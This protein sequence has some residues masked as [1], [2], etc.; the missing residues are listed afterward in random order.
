MAPPR[1]PAA[2][3]APDAPGVT[4]LLLAW[5]AGDAAALDALIPVVYAEL[6]TQARRAMRRET[7]GHTLQ[8][9][10]LVHEAFL[11]L[12][13]QRRIAWRNRAQFFGVAAQLMR[14]IL[15]DSL[16]ARRATKR[17][18]GAHRLTL[19]DA[20]V[21][22]EA[23]GDEVLALHEALE[24]LAALDPAQARLVELRYFGGL[25]IEEAAEVLGV[26]AAT[27]KREWAVAR[28]WLR[29]ELEDA[30]E[31]PAPDR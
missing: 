18:G 24:R 25:T 1:E 4:E 22:V 3:P 12:V 2:S 20:D 27:V 17:G 21:A 11:R 30:G 29:R 9:T 19:G 23:P 31:R 10:A 6:R 7:P 13:D 5:G 15:V 14:R 26:S 16:R 8:T 28:A